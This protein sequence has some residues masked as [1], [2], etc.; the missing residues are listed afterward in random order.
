MKYDF[1][2]SVNFEAERLSLLRI[3][4]KDYGFKTTELFGGVEE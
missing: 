3:K 4:Y 1:N 2:Q